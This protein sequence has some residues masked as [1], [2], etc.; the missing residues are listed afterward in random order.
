MEF[1]AVLVTLKVCLPLK[2]CI[3][4]SSN[5]HSLPRQGYQF[6]FLWEGTLF[7]FSFFINRGSGYV[8]H[9]KY[10]WKRKMNAVRLVFLFKYFLWKQK[11]CVTVVE[12]LKVGSMSPI[13]LKKKA[14]S[15]F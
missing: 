8:G 1:M 3:V 12:K 11:I 10:N 2:A 13:A 4:K 6:G 14:V 5:P 15:Y 7:E 9:E